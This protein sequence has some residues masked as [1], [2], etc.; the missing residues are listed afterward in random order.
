MFK[1]DFSLSRKRTLAVLL[2]ISMFL[3]VVVIIP[4]NVAAAE[5][6]RWI[7]MGS[8][9]SNGQPIYSSLLFH[10]GTPYLI[11]KDDDNEVKVFE[12]TDN[13]WSQFPSSIDL[14][15]GDCPSLFV[16]DSGEYHMISLLHGNMI[17]FHKY[18]Q[19]YGWQFYFNQLT[20]YRLGT[21]SVDSYKNTTYSA[22][23]DGTKLDVLVFNPNQFFSYNVYNA[24]GEVCPDASDSYIGRSTI[25][26]DPSDG[27]IYVAYADNE[28]SG[29]AIVKKYNGSSWVTVG[30]AGFSEGE[31]A[32]CSLVVE[33]GTPYLAYQSDSN[34]YVEK[35]ED[36]NWET[37]G[38]NPV[39]PSASLPSMIID[40]GILYLTS[41]E[42][43]VMKFDGTDWQEVEGTRFSYVLDVSE[44]TLVINDGILY[45]AYVERYY[46]AT[47]Q[48]YQYEV[49]VKR[50]RTAPTDILLDNDS[51][52][53]NMPVGTVVGTLA[54]GD[55][56][57]FESY[58]YT[59]VSGEGDEDNA[60]FAIQEDQLKTA[61]IFDY[62][63]KDTYS[64]RIA[65]EDG[66][67]QRYEKTFTILIE[68]E[69]GDAN[70]IL[71][72]L[73]TVPQGY[74]NQAYSYTPTVLKGDAPYAWSAS[75][76]PAGLTINSDTGEISGTPTVVGTYEVTLLVTDNRNITVTNEIEITITY[77][78]LSISSTVLPNA[79]LGES[80]SYTLRA[81]GGDYDFTWYASGLPEGMELD[82]SN[83]KI[84]GKPLETGTFDVKVAVCD[85]RNMQAAVSYTLTVSDQ[86]KTG[87]YTVTPNTDAGYTVG[88]KN[89]YKTMTVKSGVTGFRYFNV[90]VSPSVSH[91]GKETVIFV[92]MRGNTQIAFSYV[93]AD[94]DLVTDAGAGFNVKPGDVI[95]VY[96]VDDLT[97]SVGNNPVLLQ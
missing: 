58:E 91:A 81:K 52:T 89:G 64:I 38:T 77:D 15:D 94:F 79:K 80:Y 13:T 66:G 50:L 22:C 37:I 44:T 47:Q 26:V 74:Y 82:Y 75:G 86:T 9:E 96:I 2:A 53:E 55:S 72:D 39:I 35:Y 40:N 24:I 60:S 41:N 3:S 71:L 32:D 61:E 29:R 46:D 76:L 16:T 17:A 84:I 92:Q 83:G 20:D 70:D 30:D 54:A 42:C 69:V 48:G 18:I 36:G 67:G 56:D 19:S 34:I 62:E 1:R 43:F 49:R 11:F 87:K 93:K 28:N 25:A 12:Y 78:D 21:L 65:V 14:P 59:L 95:K 85:G 4:R 23:I 8:V 51:V 90:S 7:Q 63:I 73:E 27:T 57:A 6:V 5:D 68:D 10:D 45:I 31:M 88:S 33:N 97:N